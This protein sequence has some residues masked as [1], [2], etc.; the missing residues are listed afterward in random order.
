MTNADMTYARN[1]WPKLVE[2]LAIWGDTA[3][4][5]AAYRLVTD[6]TWA[7]L[8]WRTRASIRA[9]RTLKGA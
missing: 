5:H 7:M 4:S 6:R 9:A 8:V 3:H 2:G 1:R